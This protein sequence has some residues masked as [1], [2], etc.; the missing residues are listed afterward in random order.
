[1]H[2]FPAPRFN[3]NACPN[4][5]SGQCSAIENAFC[6]YDGYT[7]ISLAYGLLPITPKIDMSCYK[8]NLAKANG[9]SVYPN[10]TVEEAKNIVR[11]TA[12]WMDKRDGLFPEE[13]L[14]WNKKSRHRTN[15]VNLILGIPF[16]IVIVGFFIWIPSIIK[17]AKSNK[18]D[19]E[20]RQKIYEE[21]ADDNPETTLYSI[22]KRS[23]N[24]FTK[25]LQSACENGGKL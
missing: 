20:D 4:Y 16:S 1:M 3:C 24:D 14:A 18:I 13:R 17:L 2:L 9:E 11:E 6:I 19:E 15:M 21:L 22:S 23:L 12:G 8:F 10:L 25:A 5:Q 7:R